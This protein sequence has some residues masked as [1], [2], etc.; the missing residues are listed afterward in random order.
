MHSEKGSETFKSPGLE[1][2]SNQFGSIMCLGERREGPATSGKQMFFLSLL[3]SEDEKS[4][5]TMLPHWRRK[6]SSQEGLRS[7]SRSRPINIENDSTIF[8]SEPPPPHIL[9][10]SNR[11][12]GPPMSPSKVYARKT[13]HHQHSFLCSFPLPSCRATTPTP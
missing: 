4:L 5:E 1:Q 12:T 11:E 6:F 7:V 3:I 2:P 13:Y 8:L 10:L 9:T